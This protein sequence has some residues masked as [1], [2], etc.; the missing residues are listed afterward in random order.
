[1]LYVKCIKSNLAG[2][3]VILHIFFPQVIFRFLPTLS[4]NQMLKVWKKSK[5][6]SKRKVHVLFF[7]FLIYILTLIFC[8]V[9]SLYII[10]ISVIYTW[11]HGHV[12][13]MI[14]YILRPSCIY[15]IWALCVLRITLDNL[16]CAPV[17]ACWALFGSLVPAMCNRTSCA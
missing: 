11:S 16:Y 6:N 1:M 3:L 14:A 13:F 8:G 9:Q 12:V 4:M 17:L 10:H 15:K 5:Y 2:L 7:Y